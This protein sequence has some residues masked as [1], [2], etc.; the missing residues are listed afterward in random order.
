MLGVGAAFDF[1]AGQIKQ[2]PAWLQ[3]VGMEW[4]FRLLMEPRRLWRRYVR[5]NPRY[6][7]LVGLQLLGL[8]NFK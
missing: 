1:H 7:F 4:V 3:N 5:H 2:A 8:R 6:A